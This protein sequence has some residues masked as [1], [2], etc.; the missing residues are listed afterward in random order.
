MFIIPFFERP[1]ID[2]PTLLRYHI[3]GPPKYLMEI[4]FADAE[5]LRFIIDGAREPEVDRQGSPR[6]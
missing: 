4:E 5:P 3:E 1:K 6:R 2:G